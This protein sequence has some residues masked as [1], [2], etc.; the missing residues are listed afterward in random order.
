MF[1][2]V[3]FAFAALVL[4]DPLPV[5]LWHGMGDTCCF[6]FSMGA[7]S[8]ALTK[9]GIPYVH[10]IE[11]GDS[12]AADE[13]H[14]FFGN[15]NDAVAGVCKSLKADPKLAG[16]F[17]AIGFS[18]GGQFLRAYVERCNDPPVTN[19][20]S[21]GGQHFGVS[22]IPSCV[23]TNETLCRLMGEVLGL[24]AY[25]PGVNGFSVQAQYFRDPLQ[26]DLYLQQNIFLPDINN[27]GPTK[28]PLYKR[29]LESLKNFVLIK[30]LDDTTVV[31]RASEWFETFRWGTLNP[32]SIIPYN[33]TD[34]YK[35]DWIGL[36]TLDTTQRL[37]FLG[38]PGEH[39][40]FSLDYLHEE[41]TLPYLLR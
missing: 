6:P 12:V 10:S 22:D 3:L 27:E 32:A 41:V 26:R 24:G 34:L 28:N 2:L 17:N 8:D 13:Y 4:A 5:V 7:V 35:E 31:P 38:C 20:I 1:A 11:I 29:N 23:G 30:F 21:F 16:G 15:V 9:S 40:Q 33:E 14:G 25:L 36:R 18:Q 39:M 19:L 37:H